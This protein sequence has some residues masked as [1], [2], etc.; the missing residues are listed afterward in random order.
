MVAAAANDMDPRGDGVSCLCN[1]AWLDTMFR[2]C[3]G[4][5]VVECEGGSEFKSG[6]IRS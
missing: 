2:D 4:G 5:D 6:A 3:S 1:E